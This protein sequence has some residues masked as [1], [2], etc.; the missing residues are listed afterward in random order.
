M[1]S[2]K[3]KGLCPFASSKKAPQRTEKVVEKGF[4]IEA[5]ELATKVPASSQRICLHWTRKT[6]DIF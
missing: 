3:R 4:K 1:S 6:F 2:K 5:D